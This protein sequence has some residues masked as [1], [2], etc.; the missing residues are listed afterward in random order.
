MHI[1]RWFIWLILYAV[2]IFSWIVFFEY[3][4]G[5]GKFRHGAE[6]EWN[7]VWNT[8]RDWTGRVRGS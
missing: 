3:G 5:D 6:K 2:G 7:R 8:V 1:P 4:A